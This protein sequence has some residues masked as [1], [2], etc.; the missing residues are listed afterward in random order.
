MQALSTK[1]WR[2]TLLSGLGGS[3]EFYDFVIFGVFATEIGKNFFPSHDAWISLMATFSA[4]AAGY[5]A[6]P[7]GGMLFGHYGDAY[8]RKT[9]FTLTMRIM[10]TATLCIAILPS[11][12]TIGVLAPILFILLRIAQGAALGGEIPGAATFIAEYNP[13]HRGFACSIL[14]VFMNA[15]VLLADLAHSLLTSY[16][17]SQQNWRWAFIVGS[18]LALI[19]YLIRRTLHE[20]P[21]FSQLSKRNLQPLTT[22][23][24]KH[25]SGLLCGM[26][27]FMLMG[28]IVSI[29][30]LYVVSYMQIENI[31]N[32][33]RI[34]Q[35]TIINTMI[36]AIS[37]GVWGWL[38]DRLPDK[39]LLYISIIAIPVLGLWF[40]HALQTG[41]HLMLSY[42]L[43]SLCCGMLNGCSIGWATA[44]F[45]VQVRFSGMA[46]SYNISS[47]IF[48]GTSPLAATYLIE[49]YHNTMLP[50]YMV[51]IVAPITLIGCIL[52]RRA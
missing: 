15:G 50:A 13:H 10:A 28:I 46:M 40:Y 20:T 26:S 23:Y 2:V 18:G 35:L 19:G 25:I 52:S 38:S 24:Q 12:Q 9:I 17:S 49:H 22:L 32:T 14:M 44:L 33:F 8:S 41:Q 48:S 36:M 39:L 43:L 45:P 1:Q 37:C 5:L 51:A 11:Y 21:E 6:R 29:F 27:L 34:S 7:L 16:S 4:F 30:Y 3:L 42:V 31:A 47:A